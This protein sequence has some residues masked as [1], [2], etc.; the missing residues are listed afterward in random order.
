MILDY[1][2]HEA[3]FSICCSLTWKCPEPWTEKMRMMRLFSRKALV[4]LVSLLG[5]VD[6]IPFCWE[7][8]MFLMLLLFMM[9]YR[10]DEKTTWGDTGFETCWAQGEENSFTYKH[11]LL[12]KLW[13]VKWNM[14]I[15]NTEGS[16]RELLPRWDALHRIH[17]PHHKL[18]P[19]VSETQTNVLLCWWNHKWP[20]GPQLGSNG[21][22]KRV[23]RKL[24]MWMTLSQLLW[25][26]NHTLFPR[27]V[28]VYAINY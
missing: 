13:L 25:N 14:L 3:T 22:Q 24:L 20:K 28:M 12:M 11:Y 26:C 21:A 18:L 23:N 27:E 17:H 1:I 10:T 5:V 2:K 7:I 19:L 6:Q 8:S 9:K 16:Q 4:S 15:W